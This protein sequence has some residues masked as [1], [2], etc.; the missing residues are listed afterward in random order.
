M[1]RTVR[2]A[3]LLRWTAVAM[4]T[5]LVVSMGILLA[6]AGDPRHEEMANHGL[7]AIVMLLDFPVTIL[8]IPLFVLKVAGF[9][10][11]S[12]AVR[13]MYIVLGGLQWYLIASL[14][15]RWTCGFQKTMPVASKRFGL[16]IMAGILLVIGCGGIPWVGHWERT[17]HAGATGP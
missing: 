14:L 12:L 10:P 8:T 17:L 13:T 3:S 11:G 7:Q 16:A 5:A 2:L 6:I 15:A 4:H 1:N 9:T